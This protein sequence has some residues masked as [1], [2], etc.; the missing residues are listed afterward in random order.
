MSSCVTNKKKKKKQSAG[1]K[2]VSMESTCFKHIP[3]HLSF[4]FIHFFHR[5]IY[6]YI[7]M[8]PVILNKNKRILIGILKIY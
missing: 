8:P 7:Y 3:T 5:N 6:M 1:Y 2:I 4:N